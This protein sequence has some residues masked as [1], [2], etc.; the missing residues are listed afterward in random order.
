[1]KKLFWLIIC[2]AGMMAVLLFVESYS[3][4]TREHEIQFFV[5]KTTAV[6]PWKDIETD[7]T[8]VFFPSFAEL[9]NTT[10][11]VPEGSE[12]T[13]DGKKLEGGMDCS[14]YDWN[15]E[16]S[17]KVD[18]SSPETLV[19]LH[20]DNLST[21]CITTV[22]EEGLALVHGDK[23]HKEY[24][25]IT[26]Y[27]V[28][29]DVIYQGD[30]VDKIRGHGNSTWRS[31]K[32][33]YNLYLEKPSIL[34]GSQASDKWILLSNPSDATNLRNKMIFDFAKKTGRYSWFSPENEYVDL[35]INGE[36]FGLYLLCEHIE[37][38]A[39]KLFDVD[40]N[41]AWILYQYELA[42]RLDEDKRLF[43]PYGEG[44]EIIL[45]KQYSKETVEILLNNLSAIYQKV[46]GEQIT[47]QQSMDTA[48]AHVDLDSWCR[49]YLIE[50]VFCNADSGK[51]SQLFILDKKNEK[52]Y[53]GP[54]WDY[55]QSLGKMRSVIWWSPNTFWAS[56]GSVYRDIVKTET[57]QRYILELYREEFSPALHKLLSDELKSYI[58]HI[59]SAAEMNRI[60]WSK[61]YDDVSDTMEN[62]ESFLSERIEFL[63]R[64]WIDGCKYHSIRFAGFYA[65]PLCVIEG[66]SVTLPSPEEFAL[67]ENSVWIREDTGE[68]YALFQEKLTVDIVLR[69]LVPEE[70]HSQNAASGEELEMEPL[71]IRMRITLLS[72][73]VFAGLFAVFYLIDY[74]RSRR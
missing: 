21:M 33:P 10:V 64:V 48:L 42:W 14:K 18:G 59:E 72:L 41:D 43:D 55:D 71:S 61:L 11:R 13:L 28:T 58:E 4:K 54:C 49:K 29:G 15:K 46:D 12:I 17:L 25:D 24:V 1:M 39:A 44:I 35:Y 9:S 31:D 51:A 36:Y 40:S 53:A 30:S 22:N 52:T 32:K 65:S 63:D 70:Q 19:F 2:T 68:E 66:D 69:A 74:R 56:R 37:R 5:N 34:T 45:P 27:S 16:Y 23:E 26:M 60:R 8:Y 73:A 50:E 3:S 38:T 20:S 6:K 67:P 7:I 57:A 47:W 62:L